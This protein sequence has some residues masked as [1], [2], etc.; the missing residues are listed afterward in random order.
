M[1]IRQTEIIIEFENPI[2]HLIFLEEYDIILDE[3]KLY[4][5]WTA[6]QFT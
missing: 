2:C 5:R 1:T 4:V 6:W 3:K